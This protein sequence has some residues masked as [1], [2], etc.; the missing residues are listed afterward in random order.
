MWSNSVR[1]SV[2]TPRIL[3]P[4]EVLEL[5]PIAFA[6]LLEIRGQLRLP[7]GVSFLVSHLRHELHL[8][9]VP[10]VEVCR[11][12]F[13]YVNAKAAV[14][15]RTRD[16]DENTKV[17]TG[18]PWTP[19]RAVGAEAVFRVLQEPLQNAHMPLVL[20]FRY[21]PAHVVFHFNPL[22]FFLFP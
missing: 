13:R 20:L 17:D 2:S 19:G 14:D 16:A 3:C 6:W 1:V 15:A 9:G 5:P 10:R 4:D 21:F 7:V 8:L 22:A 12:D 18:P 11:P